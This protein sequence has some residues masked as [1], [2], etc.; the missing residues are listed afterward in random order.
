MRRRRIIDRPEAT[1]R[2]EGGRLIRISP[3]THF[4]ER[5][6]RFVDQSADKRSSD[7]FSSPVLEHV[8]VTDPADT[9]PIQ[10]GVYVQ[11]AD[12]NR[13]SIGKSA[14]KTFTRTVERIR[15]VGPVGA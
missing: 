5:P 2:I 10:I 3:Q 6:A 4:A 9:G 7:R 12:A 8:K 14:E 1:S 15:A 11:T 13:L